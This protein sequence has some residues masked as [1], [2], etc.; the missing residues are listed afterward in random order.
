VA[1]EADLQPA[2]YLYSSRKGQ[3]QPT[4]GTPKTTIERSDKKPYSGFLA[5][6]EENGKTDEAGQPQTMGSASNK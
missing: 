3:E 1:P 6:E 4:I 2:A 5:Q